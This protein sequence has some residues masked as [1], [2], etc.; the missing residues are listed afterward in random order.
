MEFEILSTLLTHQPTKSVKCSRYSE[1]ANIG[2]CVENQDSF[3]ILKPALRIYFDQNILLR[4]K[5]NFQ[6]A[7]AMKIV[8]IKL[9]DFL[10]PV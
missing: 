8:Y 5:V 2:Y 4:M 9:D 6:E 7:R 10:K 1:Y 3:K